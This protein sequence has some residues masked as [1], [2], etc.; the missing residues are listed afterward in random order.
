MEKVIRSTR[1]II[2]LS[3]LRPFQLLLLEPMCLCLNLYLAILLGILYLFFGAFPLVFRTNHD[4]NL[5]QVGLTFLGRFEVASFANEFMDGNAVS[6]GV[7]RPVVFQKGKGPRR[8]RP[9]LA[10]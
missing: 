4:T 3:L 7:S 10:R 9:A 8:L 2:A 1:K 5:W 6:G